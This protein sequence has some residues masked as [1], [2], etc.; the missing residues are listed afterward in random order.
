MGCVGIAEAEVKVP[1]IGCGIRGDG[2]LGEGGLKVALNIL[3][4]AACPV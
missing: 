4:Q 2:T 1:A 3:L